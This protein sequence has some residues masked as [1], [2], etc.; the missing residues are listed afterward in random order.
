MV[1][2]ASAPPRSRFTSV[3]S[4]IDTNLAKGWVEMNSEIEKTTLLKKQGRLLS[5]FNS[6][7]FAAQLCKKREGQRPHATGKGSHSKIANAVC[8]IAAV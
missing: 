1:I 5:I 7:F 3:F 6:L 4:E 8:Q 2:H